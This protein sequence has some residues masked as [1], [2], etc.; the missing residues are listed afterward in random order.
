[1][2]SPTASSLRRAPTLVTRERVVAPPE[3]FIYGVTDDEL[4][5]YF[6]GERRGPQRLQSWWRRLPRHRRLLPPAAGRP[7][8]VEARALCR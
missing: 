6:K 3:R 5:E 1:M 8:R 7:Q 2:A 4:V